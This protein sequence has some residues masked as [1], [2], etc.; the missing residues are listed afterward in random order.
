M[1]EKD[2]SRAEPRASNL[3]SH[4][5]DWPTPFGSL[6]REM[7]RLF[8]DFLG[9]WPAP[10]RGEGRTAGQA[11][12]MLMPQI[13]VSEADGGYKLTAE[14]PGIPEKDIDVSVADGVVT[15]KGEKKE[16]KEEKKKDYHVS[17]RRYGSFQR[18]FRLPPDVDE[19]KIAASF[20]NGVLT[21]DMP[22]SAEAKASRKKIEV[23][24]A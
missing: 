6:Q 1:A 15:I 13:D 17:E 10:S 14:L 3:P 11:G 8:D 5:F 16:E 19:G 4:A 23:K 21:L 2:V 9:G 24:P 7:N 12:G 20:K 22:K 18:S